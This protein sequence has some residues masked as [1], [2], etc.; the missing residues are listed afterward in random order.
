MLKP[1]RLRPLMRENKPILGVNITFVHPTLVEWFAHAGFDWIKFDAEHGSVS[2][3]SVELGVLAAE[4][5]G[6]VPLARV[7]HAQPELIMRF[8]DTGLAGIVVPHVDSAAD[9]EAA[10][11]AVKYHPRGERGLGRVRAAGYYNE[12]ARSEYV[13]FANSETMVLA[14]IESV[15]GVENIDEIVDV[16]DLDVLTIGTSDLSHSLGRPGEKDNPELLDMVERVLEVGL[17][18]GKTVCVGGMLGVDRERW[19]AR[20]ATWVGFNA[21]ELITENNR[22]LCAQTRAMHRP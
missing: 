15:A 1:N 18:A 20:G 2:I 6:I 12:M 22:A 19:I 9:A 14:M 4:A 7:P 3:E 21:A 13:P 16:E 10:V 11:R 5:A 8:M 17:G